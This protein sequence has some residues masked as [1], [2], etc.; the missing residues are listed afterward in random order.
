MT[1]SC[2]YC[3]AKGHE[4]AVCPERVQDEAFLL[5]SKAKRR[6][7]KPESQDQSVPGRMT[8]TTLRTKD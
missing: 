7:P 3:G 8:F 6:A 2:A 4:R 5:S 1:L